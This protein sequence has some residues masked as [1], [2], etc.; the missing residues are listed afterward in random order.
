MKIAML[1]LSFL[2]AYPVFMLFVYMVAKVIFSPLDKIAEEQE[3]ER[4]ILLLKAKRISRKE[5]LVHA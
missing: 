1:I 4:Y 5:K 2:I 3:R